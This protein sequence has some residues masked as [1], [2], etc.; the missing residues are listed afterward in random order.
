MFWFCV[1]G[2]LARMPVR[3]TRGLSRAQT[4]DVFTAVIPLCWSI[5]M[6]LHASTHSAN[7]DENVDNATL[8]VHV[9]AFQWG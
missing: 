6:L 5:T 3:E 9:I 1:R 7:F 8:N 2:G 4:G